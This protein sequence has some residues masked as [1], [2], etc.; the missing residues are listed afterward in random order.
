MLGEG[1]GVEPNLSS[2]GGVAMREDFG[3]VIGRDFIPSPDMLKIARLLGLGAFFVVETEERTIFLREAAREQ[4]RDRGSFLATKESGLHEVLCPGSGFNLLL[5]AGSLAS[6]SS[7]G[8]GAR[9]CFPMP[10]PTAAEIFSAA[11]CLGFASRGVKFGTESGT[12]LSK[13]WFSILLKNLKTNLV[14]FTTCVTRSIVTTFD[15]VIV[16]RIGRKT[17][18]WDKTL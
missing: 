18:S 5:L 16:H 3:L 10:S 12:E 4:I 17:A 14:I 2:T 9:L 8:G 15:Q 13:I 6:G 1:L 11:W 7:G